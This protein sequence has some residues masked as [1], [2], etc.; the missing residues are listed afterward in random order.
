MGVRGVRGTPGERGEA[1]LFS[2]QPKAL[3]NVGRK[4]SARLLSY[5]TSES[6]FGGDVRPTTF[7]VLPF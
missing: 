4:E 6:K 1:G 3:K 5:P 7:E 2:G